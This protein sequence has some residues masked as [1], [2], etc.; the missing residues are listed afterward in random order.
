MAQLFPALMGA[1]LGVPLGF[2]LI[3]AVSNGVSVSL[4][5]ALW[6]GAVVLG[7][8]VVLA[9]FTVIPARIGANRPVAQVLRSESA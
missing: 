1:I 3:D 5:P 7:A 6:L 2:G 4:P 8:V 9:L